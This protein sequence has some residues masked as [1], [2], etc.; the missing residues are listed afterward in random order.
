MFYLAIQPMPAVDKEMGQKRRLDMNN[1]N[2][3]SFRV[4]FG[5]L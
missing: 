4:V 2:N 1:T 3:A 5:T